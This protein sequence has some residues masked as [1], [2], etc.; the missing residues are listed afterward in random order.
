MPL[1]CYPHNDLTITDRQTVKTS[2]FCF[3]LFLQYY[4][5]L[6]MVHILGT[7]EELSCVLSVRSAAHVSDKCRKSNDMENAVSCSTKALGKSLYLLVFL[8][9]LPT[10]L[11]VINELLL[12]VNVRTYMVYIPNLNN[13]AQYREYLFFYISIYSVTSISVIL[14]N[15]F[16]YASHLEIL[17][18]CAMRS[19]GKSKCR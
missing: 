5:L 15:E 4:S 14:L 6:R 11:Y 17:Y 18:T 8:I 13:I 7:E 3:Y 9:L 10:L 1:R 19:L 2:K 12:L 16:I